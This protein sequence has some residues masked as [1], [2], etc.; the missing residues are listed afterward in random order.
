MTPGLI[1]AHSHPLYA[2]NRFAEIAQRSAGASY[3][4]IAAS[5]GGIAATV[6]ATRAA[7][8]DSLAAAARHRLRSWLEGARPR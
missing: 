4:Q 2:G 3:S 8:S 5:G 1:G 6:T 7:S